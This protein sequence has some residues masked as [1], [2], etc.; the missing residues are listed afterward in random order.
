VPTIP[1]PETVTLA[2]S[3]FCGVGPAANPQPFELL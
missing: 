1:G 3:V 2:V